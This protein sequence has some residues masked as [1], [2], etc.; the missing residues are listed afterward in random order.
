[1]SFCHYLS[2]IHSYKQGIYGEKRLWNNHKRSSLGHFC[3]SVTGS[4]YRLSIHWGVIAASLWGN[5]KQVKMDAICDTCGNSLTKSSKGFARWS[6]SKIC[7]PKT[8]RSIFVRVS[9][10]KF[11]QQYVCK[12]CL[13]ILRSSAPKNK[14]TGKFQKRKGATLV[15]T[16]KRQDTRSTP[17]KISTASGSTSTGSQLARGTVRVNL[18]QANPADHLDTDSETDSDIENEA[19]EEN[20]KVCDD[21][22]KKVHSLTTL[23]AQ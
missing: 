22:I 18:F 8:V 17:S 5:G 10:R 2:F 1:M 13:K 6:L 23:F 20:F 7:T 16:P 11:S 3:F 14:K 12:E 4:N 15:C 9:E 21:S 19:P